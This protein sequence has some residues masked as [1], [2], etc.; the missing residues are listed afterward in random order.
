MVS[1]PTDQNQNQSKQLSDLPTK[2][3]VSTTD[4]T[5]EK[6]TSDRRQASP[7]NKEKDLSDWTSRISMEEWVLRTP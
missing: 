6:F 1:Q 4:S 3:L 7:T 2:V 5:N